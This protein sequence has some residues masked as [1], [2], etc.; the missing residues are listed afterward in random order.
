[1]FKNDKHQV[2]DSGYLQVSLL[3]R[4]IELGSVIEASTHFFKNNGRVNQ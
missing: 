2:Q 1:M 4:I 3:E